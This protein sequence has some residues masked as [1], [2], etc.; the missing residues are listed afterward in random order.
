MLNRI[1]GILLLEQVIAIFV[2]MSVG[3]V[4]FDTLPLMKMSSKRLEG[5]MQLRALCQEEGNR[6]LSQR[7]TLGK[8]EKT[9]SVNGLSYIIKQEVALSPVASE[10]I[11][12][13]QVSNGRESYGQAWSIAPCKP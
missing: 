9:S 4:L 2:L 10:W 5:G 1:G 6:Q 8:S 3:L 12:K 11:L 13:V 7:L